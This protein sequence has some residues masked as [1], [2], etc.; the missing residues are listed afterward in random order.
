VIVAAWRSRHHL[1][2][3]RNGDKSLSVL[4]KAF[5]LAAI[6]TSLNTGQVYAIPI[7]KTNIE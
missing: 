5:S 3:V 6:L 7:E 2:K 1:R 4:R